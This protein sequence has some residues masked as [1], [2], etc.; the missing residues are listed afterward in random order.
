MTVQQWLEEPAPCMLLSEETALST[1]LSLSSTEVLAWEGAALAA[2]QVISGE[3]LLCMA[4]GLME[5]KA[6]VRDKV[7]HRTI[8]KVSPLD[9]GL[10]HEDGESMRYFSTGESKNV[11]SE[12]RSAVSG[13]QGS[14][15][16]T[17]TMTRLVPSETRLCIH[18]S[19]FQYHLHV[20][21]YC[22][23]VSHANAG[24]EEGRGL[25]VSIPY[26]GT[27]DLNMQSL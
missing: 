19:G 23:H 10:G 20:G 8:I 22:A 18:R 7:E 12:E 9:K 26:V 15:L 14:Q 21:E 16:K 1:S 17:P 13:S 25:I 6:I 24:S 27:P 3:E 2:L 4:D 5:Q 11:R